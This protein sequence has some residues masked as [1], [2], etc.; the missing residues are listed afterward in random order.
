MRPAEIDR[1]EIEVEIPD[2]AVGKAAVLPG[3]QAE[4]H[5]GADGQR[6]QTPIAKDQP[7]HGQLP[8]V[9]PRFDVSFGIRRTGPLAKR[10]ENI[11]NLNSGQCD[12]RIANLAAEEGAFASADR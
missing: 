11:D 1:V 6:R 3:L 7:L 8:S 5:A 2:A 12:C 9:A 10:G 4:Q